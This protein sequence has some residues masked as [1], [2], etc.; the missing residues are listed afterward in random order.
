MME[1]KF[2]IIFGVFSLT[3]LIFLFIFHYLYR[4]ELSIITKST[5][6]TLGKV[7]GYDSKNEMPVS[8]PV[9]EYQVE[10]ESYQKK[11]TYSCFLETSSKS[12]QNDVLDTTY[13]FGRGKNLNLQELFPIGST[14]TVF[15]NPENPKMGYVERYAGLVKFYKNGQ[16]VILAIYFLLICILKLAF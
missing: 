2:W 12:K 14:M 8:L 3:T 9:I 15:Y 10:S 11:F 4:R 13:V 16:V 1:T 7:V 6:K 5:S